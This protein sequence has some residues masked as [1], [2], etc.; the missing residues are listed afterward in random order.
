MKLLIAL[1][2]FEARL[3][4]RSGGGAMIGVLFFLSIVTVIPFAV[5]PDLALLS[6]IGPA[7]LWI[8]AL[9]ATLL[10]LER[11]F[12]NDQEDGSLDL[13]RISS[14]PLELIIF[15]KCIAHWIITGLPLI[16]AA[17]IF[18]LFLNMETE[19]I[20]ATCLTLLVG[21]P[22]LTFFGA[23]GAS[24]TV[25]LRRGGLLLPILILPLAI[26]VMI[27]GVAASY[28][29]TDP[30]AVFRTPMLLLSAISLFSLVLAPVVAAWAIRLNEE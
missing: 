7:I 16:I 27:F 26:P 12:K 22:A 6:R 8:G 24:L 1:F 10:G 25:S 28:A 13:L 20:F 21:T 14:E 5:G 4:V 18:A 3:A 23:I 30:I 17:P 2:V 11:L 29:A 9:L 19:A 15:V